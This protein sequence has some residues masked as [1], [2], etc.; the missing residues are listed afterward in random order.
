MSSAS[1][2]EARLFV[3]DDVEDCLEEDTG[4]ES[5]LRLRVETQPARA[6]PS[7]GGLWRLLAGAAIVAGVVWACHTAA[8]ARSANLSRGRHVLGLAEE[9]KKCHTARPGEKCYKSAH[10]AQTDGIF[11]HPEWYPH[12]TRNSGIAQ[13]QAIVHAS[14]AKECPH[15]PCK[16]DLE[17]DR[18]RE[19]K[20]AAAAVAAAHVVPAPAPA[21]VPAPAPAPTPAPAGGFHFETAALPARTQGRA[22]WNITCNSPLVP[23]PQPVVNGKSDHQTMTCGCPPPQILDSASGLCKYPTAM[24]KMTF[25]VYRAQ[26]DSDYPPENVNVADLAGVMWYLHNEVVPSVPRK[27]GVTRVLRYKITLQNTW[28]FYSKFPKQF[29]PFVAFDSAKCTAPTCNHIWDNYGFVVGCQNL[30]RNVVNVARDYEPHT[31]PRSGADLIFR[32]LSEEDEVGEDEEEKE[33]EGKHKAEEAKDGQ[34]GHSRHKNSHTKHEESLDKEAHGSAGQ[35]HR[36]HG[37][38]AKARRTLR[39]TTTMATTTK[40]TTTTP[41]T[42]L[43]P[44]HD[45]FQ[46]GIWYSLPGACPEATIGQKSDA[47]V[48]RMPGGRC[49]GVDGSKDCT[50][51]AEPAGQISLDE[52]SGIL[53][54]EKGILSYDDWWMKSYQDCL[55]AV[56]R[57]ERKGPCPHNMEYNILTDRGVGTD[58]WNGKHDLDQGARRMARVRELFGNKY[59]DLPVDLTE[60]ACL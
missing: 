25:Y 21:P 50:Y 9:V 11:A 32:K 34:E 41:A 59:P 36:N 7:A 46:G 26:G 31:A 15:A 8:A 30:D 18:R 35:T 29:G 55:N 47:C 60:P 12:L 39:A 3:S 24:S 2:R 37:A 58:F 56:Q 57:G 28:E 27:F 53:D 43:T 51:D 38:D 48:Q 1:T 49:S 13:F 22:A 20:A 40:V 16:E 6:W 54:E 42:T 44:V 33:E 23:I 5:S 4:A 45:R 10:W 14:A 19:K 52:L 17:A